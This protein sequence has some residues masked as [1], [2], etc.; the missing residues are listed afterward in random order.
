MLSDLLTISFC[1]TG[2]KKIGHPSV[3]KVPVDAA[4]AEADPSKRRKGD[5]AKEPAEGTKKMKGD[6]VVVIS[7][8][9]FDTL[10]GGDREGHRG[11]GVATGR[12]CGAVRGVGPHD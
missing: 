7:D 6:E 10:S 9:P 11:R 3:S 5:D 2:V 8:E 1:R 12:D 4:G